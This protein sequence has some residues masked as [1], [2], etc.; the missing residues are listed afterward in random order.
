MLHQLV[1]HAG[2]PLWCQVLLG[3]SGLVEQWKRRTNSEPSNHNPEACCQGGNAAAVSA[4]RCNISKAI[5]QCVSWHM[6]VIKPYL[7]IVHP[8]QACFWAIVQ[9]A[10][11]LH[12]S[13]CIVPQAHYK[14]VWAFPFASDRQLRKDGAHLA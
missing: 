6:H 4:V 2:M 10:Y 1:M 5:E 8:I 3:R 11:T 12:G 7:S 9:D 13:S 14:H